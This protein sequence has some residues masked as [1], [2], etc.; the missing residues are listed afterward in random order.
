MR[1][2]L[3]RSLCVFVVILSLSIINWPVDYRFLDQGV[4]EAKIA[5]GMADVRMKT[6]V[7]DKNNPGIQKAME[8]Q[9][10]HTAKLM[11]KSDVVGTAVGLT[12]NNVPAILVFTKK[13]L[14]AGAIPQSLDGIPV[15][16]EVTGEIVTMKKGGSPPGTGTKIDP[17]AWWPRP[18]PIG[19]STGNAGECSAGT[20][21]ARVKKSN[22][23]YA[24]SN[25]H[26]YALENAA[27]SGSEILQPGLYD[28]SCQYNSA[29]VIGTL[30]RY[31]TIQFNNTSCPQVSSAC[32]IVDAAIASIY[33][34]QAGNPLVGKATPSDGYGMPNSTTQSASLGQAVQKYGRTTSLT[35]GTVTGLNAT[36]TV[37]YGASGNA[38]FTGQIIIGS[39]RPFLKAGDSG[40]LVVTDDANANPVGLVF[41]GSGSGKYAIANPIDQVLSSFGVTIDGR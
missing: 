32:N 29:N 18:V 30:S 10:R 17:T 12:G 13:A 4:A 25:N 37:S 20:I 26:V 22:N 28:T 27:D 16:A 31:V 35:R 33:L 23:V 1:N 39:S 15:V 19:V 7:P 2:S 24:L 40:S 36:V 41:A 3:K 34:D 14:K 21:G 38:I 9:N 6:A 8:V 11:A 5:E